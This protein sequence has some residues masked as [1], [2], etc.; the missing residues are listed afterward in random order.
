MTTRRARK[1]KDLVE[2]EKKYHHRAGIHV[3]Q[4]SQHRKIRCK[5]LARAVCA[6]SVYEWYMLCMQSR[7][8]NG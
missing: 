1:H 2:F 6:G 7:S 5:N 8:M 3:S 4:V